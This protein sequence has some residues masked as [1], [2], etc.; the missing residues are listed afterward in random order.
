[1]VLLLLGSVFAISL[2]IGIPIAFC[3]GLCSL[4]VVLIKG[5][6]SIV[7][8]AQKIFN[9]MDMFSLMAI[10]LFILS[11]DLMNVGGVT[12]RLIKF[13]KSPDKITKGMAIREN[14]SIPLNI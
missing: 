14:I 7:L 11:G 13:I 9:G 6:Y 4:A 12:D 10:L 3:L 2:I 5:E 1:M 8:V